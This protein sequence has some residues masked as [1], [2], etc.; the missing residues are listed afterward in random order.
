MIKLLFTQRPA[1]T[2]ICTFAVL[3]SSIVGIVIPSLF[4][5]STKYKEENIFNLM[6]AEFIMLT[7]IM[8][9]NLIFFRG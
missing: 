4:V 1:V 8:I 7:V 9:I 5:S 6:L 3:A 2:A